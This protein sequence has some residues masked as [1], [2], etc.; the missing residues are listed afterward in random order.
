MESL[1]GVIADNDEL[2]VAR[3]SIIHVHSKS[4]TKPPK[5]NSET[6]DR[7]MVKTENHSFE[8]FA[9]AE[10][11]TG[12]KGCGAIQ[13]ILMYHRGRQVENLVIAVGF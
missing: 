13:V 12:L 5:L 8:E 11:R 1:F 9:T 4:T 10:N 6:V 3:P 7:P 2:T